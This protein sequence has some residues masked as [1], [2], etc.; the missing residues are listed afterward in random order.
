MDSNNPCGTNGFEFVEFTA[1]DDTRELE[2]LFTIMGFTHIGQH[3]TKDVVLYRQRDINFIINHEPAR[4]PTT[5][6]TQEIPPSFTQNFANAHGASV[7]S[8]AIR[9]HNAHNCFNRALHLGAEP[10]YGTVNSME[11]KIPAIRGIGGSLLYFVDRYTEIAG[12]GGVHS[13]YD[14]DF[15]PAGRGDWSR[16][17]LKKH[18]TNIG[19]THID[20]LT[21]NCYTGNMDNW[22]DFYTRLFNFQ[23]I[24][25]F[26]IKG[27][28][29][30]LTS[31]AMS[32]PCGKIRIPLN[33]PSDPKSQ[34][35]EYLNQYKGEGIQHIA[36][37]T[38]DI[39][40]TV[41][42]LRANG[43]E[44][45][46][47]PDS[48]YEELDNRIPGHAEDLQKL[49]DNQILID[50]A[51]DSDVGLLLQIFT[52][53]VIGPVFFEVIQRKGNNGFGEGNFQAL[54]EAIERDQLSR[55]VL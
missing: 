4:E 19:L 10:Y 49:Q 46:S 13:I 24:R 48:Y 17:K 40:S 15:Y 42:N 32:S 27:E 44:F 37:S 16:R 23:E 41:T 53:T 50:G 29:T 22:A 39:Y 2:I 21:H 9:V 25:Y 45:M 11:L 28:M 8:F 51:I 33:E 43:V 18:D 6:F 54:F 35:Q 38:N 26:D 30:G 7:C 31:R 36:L 12:S 55:G 3:R 47:V 14:V 52:E 34:I 5:S 20:H 1:P